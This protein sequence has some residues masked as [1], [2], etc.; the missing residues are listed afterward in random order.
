MKKKKILVIDDEPGFTRLLKVVMRH[1]EI[2][3]ENNSLQAIEAA[4]A[5][6]PDLILL[7]IIMPELDGGDV[8]AKLKE[9]PD[10]RHIPVIFLSAL[11]EPGRKDILSKPISPPDLERCIRE[12]L[13]D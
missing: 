7:D 10:L 2:R 6:K 8:A 11:A 13:G 3:E 5:F 9:D 12:H 1:F 4:R